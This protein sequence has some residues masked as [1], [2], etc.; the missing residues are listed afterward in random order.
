LAARIFGSDA[1]LYG[2]EGSWGDLFRRPRQLQSQPTIP[3]ALTSLSIVAPLYVVLSG[4]LRTL[5]SV[6]MSAQLMAAAGM[7]LLLFIVVP[8]LLARSQ[9]VQLESGFQL[10][11]ASPIAFAAAAVL[12]CTLW[13]LAYDLMTFCQNLGVATLSAEQRSILL[14][15]AK[16]LRTMPW[17]LMLLALA[18]APAIGEEFF[19]RGYL[20]GALRGRLPAWAAICIVGAIFGL[21]HASMGG[22]ILVERILS[23]TLMGIALG[24]IC[25]RT[26]SVYPGMVLH[27]LH[28]SLMV[29]LAYFC[30]E[31]QAWGWDIEGQQY[32]PLPLVA[33]TSASAAVALLTLGW[34]RIAQLAEVVEP[35]APTTSAAHPIES[36]KAAG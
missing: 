28:N 3:G 33:A 21:F 15:F 8:L 9:G 19:F 2:S 5:Q 29:S 34:T 31:L 17:P 6:S 12:G 22:L 27:L 25:W 14:E 26:A 30:E 1:I 13:P 20:L 24:W 23:S 7:T 16:K 11:R 4:L 10:R 18:I 35:T 36:H 32:L